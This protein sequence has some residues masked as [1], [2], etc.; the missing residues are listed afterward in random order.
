MGGAV[1]LT[2]VFLN[3]GGIAKDIAL[4]HAEFSNCGQGL[5]DGGDVKL[6]GVLVG[7]IGTLERLES[8]NCRVG[9]ELF[10]SALEDIPANVA[11]EVRAKTVFGEKWVELV[12]PADPEE[13][14]FA[15][16]DEIPPERTM[17]PL[18]VETILN[19]SLPLLQAID[20]EHLAGA[21]EALADGFA[22]HEDA[23]IRSI[24]KGIEAL[25]VANDNEALFRQGIDVLAESSKNLEGVDDDLLAALANLD[26]VNRFTIANQDLIEEN[27]RKAPAL[28]AE[29]GDL[30]HIRFVDLVKI[31]DRG[32]TVI[33]VLSGKT[34]DVDHLLEALPRFN[35]NWNRNLNH[36]CRYRQATDEPGA[37][38]GEAVP[39][40]CWRVHN[41]IS[42]SRGPYEDPP[43]PR[44]LKAS[45]FSSVGLEDISDVGRMM[46][47][48]ALDYLAATTGPG[49]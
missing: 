2:W 31:V 23:A 16:G 3:G 26:D 44:G 12:L 42:T 21:L 37:S 43:R 34:A 18:E 33:G 4:A 28:L 11:A 14:R 29:L 15:A 30:F 36:V 22:G 48:G 20:P 8:G 1:A 49:R 9:L 39:G 46:Y 6:R 7:R 47:V 5:R 27:L 13:E 35:S 38:V 40:R 41:I 19:T 24:E 32:A 45:D 10:P 25:K 17:D